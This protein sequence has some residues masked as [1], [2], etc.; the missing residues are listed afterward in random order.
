LAMGYY[1]HYFF[2]QTE[3]QKAVYALC[4]V[5]FLLLNIFLSAKNGKVDLNYMLFNNYLLYFSAALC[6]SLFVICLCA[7]LPTWTPIIYAGKHSLIIMATHMNCRFLGI[8]YAVGNIAVTLLPFLGNVG[9]ILAC[10][11]TMII[12]EIIAIYVINRFFPFLIGVS[13]IR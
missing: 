13:K 7:A 5:I 6:G 1:L 4:S 10:S 9:Y 8:S 11:I 12:L 3:K 2:F